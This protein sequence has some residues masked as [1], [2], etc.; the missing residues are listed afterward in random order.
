M[1]WFRSWHGAPTDTKWLLIAR[2]A[3]TVPG[4]VSAV[5]WALFDYASQNED[6]GSVKGFDVETYATYSGF[7]EQTIANVIAAML[8]K[9][10][11]DADERLSAW[12]KRQPKREDD[13]T[14]RVRKHRE[15]QREEV[16]ASQKALQ[17]DVTQCNAEEHKV[18]IEQNREEQNRTEKR[19]GASAGAD[20][21][22]SDPF[23]ACLTYLDAPEANKP[24]AIARLM[25]IRY[26][27]TYKPDY[28]RIGALAK[29]VGGDYKF[30][31]RVVWESSKPEGDPHR[32]LQGI[33][34][35]SK[36]R[37]AQAEESQI[38]AETL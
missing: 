14:P 16:T 25:D 11:I 33:L 1:E 35:K 19:S 21:P 22:V 3:K 12:D 31:A 37:K 18:T 36:A 6:R 23:A 27:D 15:R 32:Y 9:G 20:A 34:N 29:Q 30:L 5:A 17:N 24:A 2:K 10:L 7:E 13:S 8:D 4:V 26:G 38:A 28:G